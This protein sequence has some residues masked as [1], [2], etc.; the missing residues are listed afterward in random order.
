MRALQKLVKNGNAYR[1]S[2]PRTFLHH[3]GWL[4]GENFILELLDNRCV[5]VRRIQ[6]GEFD[7]IASPRLLPSSGNPPRL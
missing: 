7:P 4:P 2:I 1:V 3:L 6:P 5:L